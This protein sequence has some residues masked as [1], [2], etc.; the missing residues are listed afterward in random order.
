MALDQGT[1]LVTGASAGI[2][3][4]LTERFAREGHDVVL[5]A[6][7]EERLREIAADLGADHGIEAHVVT[8]DLSQRPNRDDLHGAVHDRDLTVDYLVNNVGIGTQGKFTETD[9]DRE[10]DQVAL[11]VATPVHLTKLF[12][13]EMVDRGGGGVL[14][15]ASTAAFQPG[16]YMA[17]YYASKAHVVSFSQALHEELR[18]DDVTVTALCPG[19]VATEFQERAGNT[20]TTIGSEG[21]GL[22]R[23]QDADQVARA[24]YRGLAKGQAVT[25]VGLEYKAL[26]RLSGVLPSGI[27]RKLAADLNR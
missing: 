11:N 22:F 7:R 16:P 9:L 6:R 13:P 26:R 4:A 10:L 17:G 27:S 15:V 2:G 21:A 14:N 23:W 12:A 24:G 19:P 20:D 3:R 1:A 8:A 25:T 18:D 5:V